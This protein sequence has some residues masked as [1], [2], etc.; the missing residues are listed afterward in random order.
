M[1]SIVLALLVLLAV[2]VATRWLISRALRTVSRMTAQAAAWS[3]QD[4]D[5][6]FS[7]GVP[8]DELTQ[9]AGVLDR[10]LDRLSASLARE[11]RL[12]AE[13]AHE[14]RTPLAQIAAEAQYAI[15][16]A[17]SVEQQRAA[18][19]QVLSS[20]MQMSRTVETLIATA[21]AELDPRRATS[22]ACACAIAAIAACRPLAEGQGVEI[23]APDCRAPVPVAVEASLVERILAPLLENG[24][25]YA[26]GTVRLGVGRENGTVRYVLEDDGPGI[27]PSEIEA[28]FEPGHSGGPAD[29][30]GSG[31]G[32]GL[33]LAR[34]LARAAGGEVTAA[35]SSGGATF[36]VRLPSA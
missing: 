3:E 10:L 36:V 30:M 27:E 9:L 32:L 21:R 35:R 11:Q 12:T 13:L 26:R 20:A 24:C 29:P 6:R 1:A 23:E 16:H 17:G 4:L 5:R 8:H 22:D 19:E 2:A 15:R 18:H 25:R 31:A 7:L 14:L 34:R 28:I 33:P